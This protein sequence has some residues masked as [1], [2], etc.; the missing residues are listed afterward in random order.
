LSTLLGIFYGF[1][2]ESRCSLN[3]II[4]R[5]ADFLHYL[6]A[7]RQGFCSACLAKIRRS[8]KFCHSTDPAYFTFHASLG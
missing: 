3:H 2:S 6:W 5:A 7:N 4:K 8:Y 1:I